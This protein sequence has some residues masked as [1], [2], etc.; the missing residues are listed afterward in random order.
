MEERI[1]ALKTH[2]TELANRPGFVHSDWFV[3]YHLKI[4]EKIALEL[5]DVY[6]DADKEMAL[7][8]VWFHDYGKLIDFENEKQATQ[9][10]GKQALVELGFDDQYAATVLENIDTLDRKVDIGEA[11]I[12]VQIASSADGASHML[13]PFLTIHWHEHPELSTKELITENKRK[14]DIDWNK[15]MVLPEIKDAFR[16]RRDFLHEHLGDLPDKFLER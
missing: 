13:G 2:I 12:E 11:L 14:M 15:K 10:H 1:E 3:E 5:C 4:A 6:P 7:V 8:L 9:T 16:K